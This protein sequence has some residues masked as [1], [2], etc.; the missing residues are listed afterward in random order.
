MNLQRH[1]PK[2]AS[3]Q[4]LFGCAF[5]SGVN[6]SES[7]AASRVLARRR[8][9]LASGKSLYNYFRDYQACTGRYSQS[10]PVGLAGGVNTYAYVIGDPLSQMDPFGLWAFGDPLNQGLVDAAAGFGDG[11]S[12]GLSR[13]IRDRNNIDGGVEMCSGAYLASELAGNGAR[14]LLL[15]LGRLGYIAEARQLARLNDA[16]IAA[17][18]RNALKDRYRGPGLDRLLNKFDKPSFQSLVDKGKTTEQ[19]IAGSARTNPFVNIAA[20][21]LGSDNFSQNVNGRINNGSCK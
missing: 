7:R 15:P 16:R 11:I 4:K 21:G 10:D 14:D 8:G 19:I 9:K 12:L 5:A 17:A 1:I 2:T 3:R 6:R 13:Y 20:V 18:A